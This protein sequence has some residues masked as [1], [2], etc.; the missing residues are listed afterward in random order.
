VVYILTTLIFK[1]LGEKEIFYGSSGFADEK[2]TSPVTRSSI[3]RIYSMTKPVTVVAAL[4]LM[5]RGLLSLDDSVGR[6][7]PSFNNMTV[8]VGG[9]AA[10]PQ[11]ELAG[12]DVTIKD[13]MM[14]TSGLS[15]AIFAGGV[16]DEIIQNKLGEDWK[17]WFRGTR[18]QDLCDGLGSCPLSFQPGSHWQ[19][20]LNTDVLGRVVEVVSGSTLDLFFR[21]EIFEPLGMRDT[22]FFV[23]EGQASRLVDCFEFTGAAIP[24]GFQRSTN[25]ERDRLRPPVFLSGGGGLVST[26]DDYS[27][28]VR[29]LQRGGGLSSREGAGRLLRPETVRLMHTNHLPGGRTMG[30]MTAGGFSESLSAGGVGFGLGV[31]V[32]TSPAQATGGSL[33]APEEFGWGGVASTWFMI[34]PAKNLSAVFYTQV[35]PSTRTQ[36]RNHL[37]WL[38]NWAGDYVE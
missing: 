11:T 32:L 38:V 5:E 13:L 10:N 2:K 14:H 9:D 15:Y 30:E 7:I 3:F 31:S 4:I 33:S 19:Y 25:P 8:Y 24:T 26:I 23:R 22:G 35:I 21:Q 20:G 12:R 17:N 28:F 18:L 36:V 27:L 29:C 34:S 37:K 1:I 16:V 6:Y